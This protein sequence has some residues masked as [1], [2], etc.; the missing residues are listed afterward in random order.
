MSLTHPGGLSRRSKGPSR[1]EPLGELLDLLTRPLGLLMVLTLAFNLSLIV[2]FWRE[3]KFNWIFEA[4]GAQ[5][6]TSS[7]SWM[8]AASRGPRPAEY[9]VAPR[10]DTKVKAAPSPAADDTE[11][12]EDIAE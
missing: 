12:S 7:K 4:R 8:G 6:D 9:R 2:M 11:A 1:E 5:V 3:G 10:S